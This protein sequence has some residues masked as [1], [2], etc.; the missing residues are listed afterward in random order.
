MDLVPLEDVPETGWKLV[1]EGEDQAGRIVALIHEDTEA[2]R[3]MAVFDVV[4]NNADRKGDHIL[5]VADGHR[6]GVDHGLTLHS[7]HKL[8]TVLWGWIGEAL[9]DGELAGI[10][11]VLAGLDGELGAKL[12]D[13]LTAEEIEALAARC[14]QLRSTAVFPAPSGGMPAVPW[15]LF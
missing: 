2:L 7:D 1:L 6:Y 10:D 4:V 9:S 14:V 13:L 3:R 8:R 12:A 11:R 5:P 15:P